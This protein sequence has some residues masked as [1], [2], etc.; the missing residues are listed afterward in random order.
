MSVVAS[1]PFCRQ[2]INI[3][4]QFN[5]VLA[6]KASVDILPKLFKEKVFPTGLHLVNAIEKK[7]VDV[8]ELLIDLTTDGKGSYLVRELGINNLAA[9][10]YIAPF[11]IIEKLAA[12]GAD[13]SEIDSSGDCLLHYVL[14]SQGDLTREKVGFALSKMEKVP[15]N[16]LHEAFNGEAP[17]TF[18]ALLELGMLNKRAMKARDSDGNLFIH[19]YIEVVAKLED[20]DIKEEEIKNQIRHLIVLG[21]RLGQRNRNGYNSFELANRNPKLLKILQEVEK[22]IELLKEKRSEQKF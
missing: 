8:A 5:A 4:A 16:L 22:E 14:L 7:R 17:H 19:R 12:K 3:M 11:S 1:F 18:A 9:I 20:I 6:G 2:H 15:Y 10:L 13:F 21:A